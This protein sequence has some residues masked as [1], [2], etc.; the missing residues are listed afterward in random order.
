MF[1]TASYQYA[2]ANNDL[3]HAELTKK[4]RECLILKKHGLRELPMP[5]GFIVAL[6]LSYPRMETTEGH[7]PIEGIII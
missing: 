4:Q 2:I 1:E 7:A 6:R 3:V 5:E